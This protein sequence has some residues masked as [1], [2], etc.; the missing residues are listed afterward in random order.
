MENKKLK[1][2]IAILVVAL[3]VIIGIV[4]TII[5]VKNN[6]KDIENNVNEE[7]IYNINGALIKE[8]IDSN[9]SDVQEIK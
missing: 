1:T 8:S 4:G 9:P 2:K 6:K 3:V 5:I 7:K